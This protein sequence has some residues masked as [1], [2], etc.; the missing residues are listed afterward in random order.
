LF[1]KWACNVQCNY[2]IAV[3]DSTPRRS[4]SESVTF[5]IDSKV[6]KNL[7]H[8]AEQKDISTNTLVNQ[9]IK[10]HLNWYSNAAKAGFISVRRPFVSKVIKYLP[11]QEI[12]SLA[13][14]VAKTTNKD[15]ILI[16]KKEYTIKSA[17]DFLESWIKISGYPYRHEKTNNGQNKH[18]YI[19]QHDMGMKVSI[20][21]ATL[22]QSLF[23]ELQ[24]SKKRIEFD[25][26]ENTLAFEI[27]SD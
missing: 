1:R 15:S 3:S 4:K 17:L 9:I 18:S 11:E 16:M 22:Y 27:D 6:L 14:Y 12:I 23:D 25:K 19:I 20:Y 2:I 8:E 13:E 7:R 24:Q 5:R 21:L 26:T 10:D